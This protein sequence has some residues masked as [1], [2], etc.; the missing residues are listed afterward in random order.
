VLVYHTGE[1]KTTSYLTT[2]PLREARALSALKDLRGPRPATG[3]FE[4]IEIQNKLEDQ[5]I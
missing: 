2:L 1:K 5:A 4:L 3:I